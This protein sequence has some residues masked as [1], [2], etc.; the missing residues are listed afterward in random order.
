VSIL[1]QGVVREIKLHKAHAH[2]H[3]NRE[4][5]YDVD[6]SRNISVSFLP[7]FCFTFFA[8]ISTRAL[9]SAV[10]FVC[11]IQRLAYTMRKF[12]QVN[13]RVRKNNSIELRKGEISQSFMMLLAGFDCLVTSNPAA[14]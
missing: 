2:T 13:W 4:R 14:A 7:F 8:I 1:G 5:N 11:G 3:A 6:H 12:K 9:F 10:F